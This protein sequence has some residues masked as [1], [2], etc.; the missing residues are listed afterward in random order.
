[1][2]SPRHSSDGPIG[3][4]RRRKI[5]RRS[6]LGGAAVFLG[7][8][9]AGWKWPFG[10]NEQSS[11]PVPV[12]PPTQAPEP[13]PASEEPVRFSVI[14]DTGID[15][16][17]KNAAASTSFAAI[18]MSGADFGLHL[19]DLAYSTDEGIEQEFADFVHEHAGA[20]L[21]W[22]LIPGNHEGL[23]PNYGGSQGDMA[24]FAKFCEPMPEGITGNYPYDY[25]FDR[26]QVRIIMIS[27]NVKNPNGL[28]TYADGTP[29]QQQLGQWIDEAKAVGKFVIVGEH[30]PFLTIGEHRHTPDNQSVPALAEFQIK[31]GVDVVIAGHDHNVSRSHLLTGSVTDQK[32]P[33]VV[34]E[35]GDFTYGQG[36]VFVVL[37]TGGH[38]VRDIGK[39]T[40]IWAMGSGTNS[41]D[42][43]TFA[44]GEF[45]VTGDVIRYQLRPTSGPAVADAFTITKR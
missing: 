35:S 28:L 34:D 36:T 21:P 15:R 5:A 22:A 20:A 16:I 41:P 7:G 12:T 2:S 27:P 17:N 14:A 18:G 10:A 42:G 37:G 26:E 31:K 6:V 24:K 29:E 44:Y 40:E 3:P 30:E 1:M 23:D 45:E 8:W 38:E 43:I 19:G 25:Y 9:F 39:V 32:S 11:K 4:K 33:E 13:L